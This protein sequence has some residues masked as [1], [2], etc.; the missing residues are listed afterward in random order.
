MAN[1][2]TI[3][4][5]FESKNL[6]YFFYKWRKI[7]L[8]VGI[9]SV[10]LS[11]IFSLPYFITPK[12]KSTVIMYPTS[13]NSISK[14][15]LTDNQGPKPDILEFGE[16]EQTEQMLQILNSNDIRSRIVSKYNLMKHYDID[17]NAKFKYT[18]LYNEYEQNIQFKRTEYMAVEVDVYDRSADT[19]SL[20]ANDIA[21]LL[22]SAKNKMKKERALKGFRIVEAEYMKLKDEIRLMEDSITRIRKQGIHDYETQS[23]VITEQLAIAISKNNQA[24]VRALN[25][26]LDKLAIYG[27]A[28]VSLRNSIEYQRKQLNLIKTKY[29]EAKVDYEQELPNKFVVNHAYKAEKKSYPIRW[30]IVVISTISSLFF[31]IILILVFEKLSNFYKNIK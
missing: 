26:Q 16:E 1:N 28:Y 22:D 7:I 4:Y 17:P 14:A 21:A 8:I 23:E 5:D 18:Q 20:I 3:N 31:T 13:T 25:L 15:L 10:I 19:A 6:I 2:N 30:L 29:D 9:G 27:G 12:F 11:Y 24:S